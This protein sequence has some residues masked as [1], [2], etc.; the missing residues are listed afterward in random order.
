MR[1]S[2]RCHLQEAAEDATD[3]VGFAT[4]LSLFGNIFASE[5]RSA[6]QSDPQLWEVGVILR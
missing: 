5:S 3:F 1:D 6:G 4:L 2:Y